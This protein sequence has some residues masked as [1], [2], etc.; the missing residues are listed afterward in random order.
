MLSNRKIRLSLRKIIVTAGSIFHIKFGEYVIYIGKE[1]LLK[2]LIRPILERCAPGQLFRYRIRKRGKYEPETDLLEYLITPDELSIDI[3]ANAGYFAYF[4]LKHTN[5]VLAFEPNPFLVSS[6]RRVLG[7]Q[8]DIEQIAL[9]DRSG[10]AILS[11]PISSGQKTSMLASIEPGNPLTRNGNAYKTEVP[12]RILD[13]YQFEKVG[14]IKIDVEGHELAVLR[15][16]QELLRRDRPSLLIESEERHKHGAIE[17]MRL[18]LTGLGYKGFFL[19]NRKITPI[20][21]FSLTEHQ[22]LSKTSERD[23]NS[24][25]VYINNFI[26]VAREDIIQK[27]ADWNNRN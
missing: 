1:I 20:E 13:D 21:E 22:K 25:S 15:G 24:E 10:T 5:K 18:F 2:R 9:S 7:K 8:I 4:I 23:S 27:L 6:L 17:D 26:Y 12:T 19:I 14:F 16:A 3:G 11:I